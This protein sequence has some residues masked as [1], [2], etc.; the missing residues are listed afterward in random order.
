MQ[1][2]TEGGIKLHSSFIFLDGEPI[3]WTL[4]TDVEPVC[5]LSI[6]R[7][8]SIWSSV[9]TKLAL[10]SQPRDVKEMKIAELEV[11]NG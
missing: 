6:N 9:L 3:Q 4:I 10:S 2:Y 5:F 11:P 7:C 8:K 1:I